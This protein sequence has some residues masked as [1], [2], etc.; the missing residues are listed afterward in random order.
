MSKPPPNDRPENR[1][2]PRPLLDGVRVI[3]LTRILAGPYCTMLLGDLGADVIKIEIPG[4]GDDTRQWG[5]PFAEGGESAYY[6]AANRNKRSLTLNLKSVRGPQVLK[7]LIRQGDVVVENFRA[8][9]M[10][11]WGLDYDALQELRPGLIYCTITG[12]GYDGPYRDRPG[13]DLIVQALGGLMSVTGPIEGEPTRAGVAIADLA[14]GMF[15]CSAVLAAL[16]A[17]ERT[18]DGQRIDIS[19]LDSQVALMSYVASNFLVSGE[20]PKR[21]G[22]AHPNIVPYEAF[23]ARDGY[24]AFAAGNDRQWETFC[25]A[26]GRPEWVDDERFSTNPARNRNRTLLIGLLNELFQEREVAE[27]IALCDEIGLPAGPI[28]DMQAVFNDPQVRARGLV[29]EVS[30]PTAGSVPVLASPLNVPTSPAGVRLPPP[31]LGQHTEEVLADVLG[32]DA[33]A[34]AA[35]RQEGVV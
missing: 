15:A 31:L 4:R 14:S 11:E 7:E 19:L 9:T 28:N 27:W 32:Y 29:Q 23:K 33:E 18:G 2:Q 26:V 30:H 20:K 34:V 8:G 35:L 17:R 1:S 22:N 16:F 25:N 5:P 3:D 13:Y 10:E 21:Y 24:L 12:Y 6:L